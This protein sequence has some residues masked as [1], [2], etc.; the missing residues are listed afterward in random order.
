MPT[1]IVN[2]HSTLV[3]DNAVAKVV[4]HLQTQLQRDFN[5]AWGIT[6]DVWF[7]D[8]SKPI[9]ADYWQ[10]AVFDTSDVANALGY[11]DLT[12][13]G[14]PLGKVFIKTTV[15]NGLA[16]SVT[17]SHELLEM[18]IDPYVNLTAFIQ[19][20]NTKG[21]F[22]AYEVGDPV[23][24]DTLGYAINS[25]LVSDFV[26]PSYFVP[27]ATGPY[28]FCGHI[29]APLQLIPGGYLSVFDVKKGSGWVELNGRTTSNKARLDTRS[30][31]RSETDLSHLHKHE[32]K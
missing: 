4:E 30:K 16:W 24:D 27:G 10:L 22:V 6:A 29:T 26:L 25:V 20:A 14:M 17:L 11:H 2:N 19:T 15:D 32:H 13:T 9:P 23:E 1:I 21:V 7:W 28:D 3:N 31:V 5:P 8:N 12:A 18:L